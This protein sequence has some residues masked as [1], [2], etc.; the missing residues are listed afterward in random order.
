MQTMIT[1]YSQK[2]R[3]KEQ[4]SK[5]TGPKFVIRYMWKVDK[6]SVLMVVCAYYWKYI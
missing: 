1:V 6:I 4:D 5:E 2:E 3:A